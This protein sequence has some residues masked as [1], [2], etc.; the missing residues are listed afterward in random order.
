M[1]SVEIIKKDLSNYNKS[2]KFIVYQAFFDL[3]VAGE[4][5]LDQLVDYFISFYRARKE[6]GLQVEDDR[7]TSLITEIESSSFKRVKNYIKRMPLAKIDHLQEVDNIV[8]MDQELWQKLSRDDIVEI[9]EYIQEKK[10]DYFTK[11]AGGYNMAIPDMSKEEI[12]AA[13]KEFDRE[14]RDK[15]RWKN[16]TKNK[17]HKYAIQ[18]NQDLYPVKEII[19]IAGDYDLPSFSGGREANNYLIERGFRIIELTNYRGQA[20]Q[21]RLLLKK[22]VG[23]S[24]F[25][26]GLTI[27]I[28]AHQDFYK[29]NQEQLTTGQTKEVKLK[30]KE[31]EYTA[32]LRNVDRDTKS[33]TLQLRY[34]SNEELLKL[35]QE[36][37][38]FS[39]HYIKQER[40]RLIQEGQQRPQVN[41]PPEKSEYLEIY[42]TGQPY[43]YQ[44][45]LKPVVNFE[46][47]TSE[48][49]KRI[50]DYIA[51]QGFS[52]PDGLIKNF[53][54]SLKTKPFVLLAGI[55]GT[56]KT[57]LVQLFAEAIGCTSENN[58]FKL[59]PVRPDWSDG[60]DLLG[61]NDLKGEFN[62]GPI[63]DIIKR[64]NN[65]QD[66]IYF[67]CLDEMNLARVEYYFSDLLS[68]METRSKVAGEVK[69][70]PLLQ[71]ED[72][73]TEQ[74]EEEYAGIY[75]SDNLF[76]VGTVN[77][78][79]TTHPFSKKVLDRANTIEFSQVKLDNFRLD[80]T[81]EE[82]KISAD[83]SFLNSEYITLNDC[84]KEDE[85]L[86]EQVVAKLIEVNEVLEEANLHIGYRVRDEICFYM[87]YNQQYGL[88][89]FEQAFDLQLMQKILPR[90]Q[91]SSR[92]IK[93]VLLDLFAIASGVKKYSG[94]ESPVRVG[95]EV[96]DYVREN[97]IKPY[98]KSAGKLA[99]MI[100][101][102]E[103]DGFTAYWL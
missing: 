31:R 4:V 100:K 80:Q 67:I 16:F 64:A 62:P 54:L 77:M 15:K 84:N 45:E 60:S 59:I 44:I 58:R 103:E 38:S 24:L 49:V 69:S 73:T 1:D 85:Q 33:T 48:K 5:E 55:S 25:N 26:W 89:D 17:N 51:A 23:W 13:L 71:A 87:L 99:D 9:K 86:I 72:F 7:A 61:Y 74:D 18:Y 79:E 28:S 3:V 21:K 41:L 36:E 78:D 40:K 101:R 82:I 56:G 2:Y 29:A 65:D 52:Y 53:Y 96:V 68:L 98:P 63:I 37:F 93:R 97:Q 39:Y 94:T 12:L 10:I 8:K 91:G 22:K 70:D 76:I 47:K 35:L 6:R 50:E 14:H 90:I 57:K 27:P 83:S 42:S 66:N 81:G 34:D 19:R 43:Y 92:V 11:Y 75:L 102:F 20:K 32:K 30:F 46:L 95:D 88:L